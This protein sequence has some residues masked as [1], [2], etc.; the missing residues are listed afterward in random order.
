MASSYP[1]IYARLKREG[2][3]AISKKEYET[4]TKGDKITA[5]QLPANCQPTASQQNINGKSTPFLSC[6]Y[7]TLP[8]QEKAAVET[9]SVRTDSETPPPEP[10]VAAAAAAFRNMP[11]S[12]CRALVR[13]YLGQL[14]DSP[15]Q[16]TVLQDICHEY[17]PERIIEAFQAAA[18]AKVGGRGGLNW[19]R[20]R[21]K[22]GDEYAGVGGQRTGTGAAAS[23]RE[24]PSVADSLTDDFLSRR[25]A[26]G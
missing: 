20:K 16:T 7:P 25:G 15:G 9:E 26:A 12:E 6:P 10:E 23:R 17:P 14:V 5:S 22:G 21:L 4:L 3:T 19:V 11:V 1:D 13:K 8:N 18:A 24:A 2:Y